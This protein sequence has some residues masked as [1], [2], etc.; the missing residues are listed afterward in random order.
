M[1]FYDNCGNSERLSLIAGPCA[2][3][4]KD[5]A[6]ETALQIEE[7]CD[8]LDINFIYK[9]SFDKANRSSADSFRIAGFDEAYYGMEAVRGRGIEDRKSTRLN[10]SHT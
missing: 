9:T 1:S 10:S 2:F 6:I 7:I 3:E 4:T 8:S 5:H